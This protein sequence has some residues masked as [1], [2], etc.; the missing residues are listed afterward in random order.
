MIEKLILIAVTLDIFS[1][2][3][4]PQVTKHVTKAMGTR[5][6]HMAKHGKGGD[7]TDRRRD[8]ARRFGADSEKLVTKAVIADLDLIDA[9]YAH[10]KANK[11]VAALAPI[12]KPKA[13]P[14]TRTV[15]KRT[16]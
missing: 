8:S 1:G 14:A 13:T 9:L 7:M 16:A 2:W 3:A 6:K 10:L 11:Q 15:T 12:A 5:S 4:K